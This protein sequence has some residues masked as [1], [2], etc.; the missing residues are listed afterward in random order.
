MID[1]SSV[2]EWTH[3]SFKELWTETFEDKRAKTT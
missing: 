2:C 1:S 3:T